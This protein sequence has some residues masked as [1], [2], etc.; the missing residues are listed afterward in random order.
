MHNHQF[1]TFIRCQAP[2]IIISNTFDLHRMHISTATTM[3][4]HQDMSVKWSNERFWH[5]SYEKCKQSLILMKRYFWH[6]CRKS[7]Q[8]DVKQI[9][10]NINYKQKKYVISWSSVVFYC[11]LLNLL[12]H[13]HQLWLLF[14][15]LIDTCSC[16]EQYTH[17]H[18][19]LSRCLFLQQTP[20]YVNRLRSN[21]FDAWHRTFCHFWN[22]RI[23]WDF[24]TTAMPHKRYASN[25]PV[26]A[27]TPSA[28]WLIEIDHSNYAVERKLFQFF[29]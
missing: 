13:L 9:Y 18:Y 11:I 14:L 23:H 26:N 17:S 25:C 20:D 4:T 15:I 10:L 3:Q 27:S 12:D 29:Q 28:D 16:Q 7:H 6:V 2:Q 21:T 19:G 8:K 5:S 22:I 24:S 1:L